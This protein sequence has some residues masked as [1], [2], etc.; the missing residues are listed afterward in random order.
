MLLCSSTKLN[1]RRLTKQDFARLANETNFEET[2]KE[3]AT[4]T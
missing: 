4:A 1:I 2:K 3:K